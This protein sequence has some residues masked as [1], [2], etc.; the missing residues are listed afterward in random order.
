VLGNTYGSQ[1]PYYEKKVPEIFKDQA[2][3]LKSAGL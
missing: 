3:R 2:A 1:F